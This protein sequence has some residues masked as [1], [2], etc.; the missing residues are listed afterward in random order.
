[1]PQQTIGAPESGNASIEAE[2]R[3]RLS[4]RSS[5]PPLDLSTDYRSRNRIIE[6]RIRQHAHGETLR[7][8]EA[9]CGNSWPLRL[10]GVR[11]V[12]TAV[13]V[14]K[15][16]LEI[17][18]SRIRDVDE[19]IVGDLRSTD[20]FPPNSFD[21]IYNSFVLE[22]VRGAELVLDNFLRWLVP[23]GL[24][25]L[26]IPD[27]DSV[28]G[29]VTR[30]TPFW[31]HKLYK[32]YVEGFDKAGLAGHGPYPTYHDRIVS[33]RA[34]HQYCREHH[35]KVL[36]EMGHGQ[37]L[38]KRPLLGPLVRTAVKSISLLS[39]GRLEWRHNNLTFIIQKS[40]LAS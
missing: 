38:P 10:D 2:V 5:L 17:R 8:L 15:E 1:M 35:C 27:R 29:F 28:Y 23:G 25:I 16:A 14:D 11:F 37:Y 7:I 31:M 4:R 32:R 12:L 22:H 30:I 18:K 9:G 36:N 20:I 33:R 19:I 13:D 40:A 39:L 6:D 21:V 24:L 34:I 26:R 3:A